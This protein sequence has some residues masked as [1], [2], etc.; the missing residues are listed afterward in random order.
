[1]LPGVGEGM[2]PM[3]AR[4]AL[5]IGAPA[6]GL[7]ALVALALGES[8]EDTIVI[9]ALA[10]GGA[11]LAS[12]VGA[13]LL[14]AARR[15]SLR[16]QAVLVAMTPLVAIMVSV[17]AAATVMFLSAHDLRV[18]VVI[19][20][21][22][23]PVGVL[24]ALVLG[25]RLQ[26][27]SRSLGELVAQLDEEHPAAAEPPLALELA[28]LRAELEESSNRMREAKAREEAL[29]RSRRELVRWVSH[30]LRTPLADIRVMI[31]A[32]EDGVAADPETVA[33][34]HRTIGRRTEALTQLVDDLFE[35]SRIHAGALPVDVT[36]VS[37]GDLV[38]DAVAT[39]SPGAE[40]RSVAIEGAVS[41]A[42]LV[43][44]VS[45]ADLARALGNLLDNAVRHTIP[46]RAVQVLARQDGDI[47]VVEV[48]DGCGG[49]PEEHLAR[50]FDVGFQGDE[51]RSAHP[52]GGLGLAIARGLVESHGGTVSVRN[53]DAG[54]RF[55]VQ[56]PL[57][58]PGQS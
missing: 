15:R 56:L 35:L 34:Y 53:Q 13:A 55:T 45:A 3:R 21:A 9:V 20:A 32:L 28:E 31:E 52:G 6:L 10:S 7:A 11:L 37:L 23:G 12:G 1:M 49:I 26:V 4:Q 19:L 17:T 5:A 48:T 46:P 30:D 44:E 47:A 43:V 58:R 54:C 38:S 42:P 2:E 27:G 36:S 57:S 41:D 24:A 39:A 40:V 8:P 18:L 25:D 22:A 33:R 50:V 51:A 16:A 29:D 14:A